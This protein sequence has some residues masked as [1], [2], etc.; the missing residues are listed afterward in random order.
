MIDVRIARSRDLRKQGWKLKEIAEAV[1]AHPKTVYRWIGKGR[2]L[3]DY[4]PQLKPTH[5][6]CHPAVKRLFEEMAVQQCQITDLAERS[7]V[8]RVTLTC[9]KNGSRKPTLR[10]LE[11]ALNVFDLEI[12]VRRKPEE[13]C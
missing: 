2:I 3:Q 13:R 6:A 8:A 5:R 10:D 11:A 7:G 1:G 4:H 9:W 12:T